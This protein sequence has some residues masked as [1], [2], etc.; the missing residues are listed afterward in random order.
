MIGTKGFVEVSLGWTGLVML[1][2]LTVSCHICHLDHFTW[3]PLLSL[4]LGAW[5]LPSASSLSFQRLRK[6]F[7]RFWYQARS[8]SL[9]VLWLISWQA[10]HQLISTLFLRHLLNSRLCVCL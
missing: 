9:A 4:S 5:H 2:C 10:A 6:T 1:C 3:M 8:C 7:S